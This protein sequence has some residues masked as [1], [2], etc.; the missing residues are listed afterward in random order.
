MPIA[1]SHICG[2][3]GGSG[4]SIVS[5]SIISLH[6][7]YKRNFLIRIRGEWLCVFL[8]ATTR[9]D[10][11]EDQISKSH[12]CLPTRNISQEITTRCLA[13]TNGMPFVRSVTKLLRSWSLDHRSMSRTGFTPTNRVVNS[14]LV[15]ARNCLRGSGF[16]TPCRKKFFH[17]R[18]RKIP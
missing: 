2:D 16:I 9:W 3:S 14:P 7:N 12:Q 4:I 5:I 17:N 11:A 18:A 8:K 15:S 6:A 10:L 1:K 13:R